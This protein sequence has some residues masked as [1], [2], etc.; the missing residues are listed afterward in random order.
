MIR[1][2]GIPY[3]PRRTKLMLKMKLVDDAECRI[4]G[5]KPGEGKYQGMLGSF[6]CTNGNTKFFVGGMNDAIRKNYRTTHPIGTLLTYTFNG[7]T[8][9]GIPRHP[10]YK[11][12]RGD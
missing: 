7:L 9:D 1:A 11:G 4:I 2:P 6:E 10:R 5:Y 12:I 8:S 3:I